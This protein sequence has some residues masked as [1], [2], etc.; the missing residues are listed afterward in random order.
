M[1]LLSAFSSFIHCLLLGSAS[2]S[3]HSSTFMAKW[4][5]RAGRKASSR[6]GE[7]DASIQQILL[8]EEMHL[9]YRDI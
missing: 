6:N 1:M 7:M 3:L 8:S 4:L 9:R 5:L 2:V